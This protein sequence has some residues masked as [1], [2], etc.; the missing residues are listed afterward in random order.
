MNQ[1]GTIYISNEDGPPLS[2]SEPN[3]D[4]QESL[5]KLAQMAENET[6]PIYSLKGVFPLDFIPNEVH[7]YRNKVSIIFKHFMWQA[8][9]TNIP[10]EHINYITVHSSIFLATLEISDRFYSEK[11]VFIK[12]LRKGDAYQAMKIV[13]G[14]KLA[15]IQNIDL[16]KIPRPKLVD[17]LFQIG[18]PEAKRNPNPSASP[19]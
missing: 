8:R 15:G 16:S 1:S 6:K 17:A 10:I 7:I 2:S 12:H 13:D 3:D 4:H 19:E 9:V 18:S 14:L 11:P 5:T